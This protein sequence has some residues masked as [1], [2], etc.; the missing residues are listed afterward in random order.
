[1]ERFKILKAHQ[2]STTFFKSYS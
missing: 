1:M 2:T